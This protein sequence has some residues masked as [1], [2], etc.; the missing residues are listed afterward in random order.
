[1]DLV[2]RAILPV[3]SIPVD[4][5]FGIRVPTSPSTSSN[6]LT[7]SYNG[8]Q[9]GVPQTATS[10]TL[11]SWL[12]NYENGK[13]YNTQFTSIDPAAPRNITTS[14]TSTS[15]D[16]GNSFT[17]ATALADGQKARVVTTSFSSGHAA[18]AAAA[19]LDGTGSTSTSSS[20]ASN[21][22]A[23]ATANALGDV[24][25]MTS[26]NTVSALDSQSIMN[27]QDAEAASSCAADSG[28]S[29]SAQAEETNTLLIP[30]GQSPDGTKMYWL[31]SSAYAACAAGV[32]APSQ[33]G[34]SS[35][36][37]QASLTGVKSTVTCNGV[38]STQQQTSTT[39]KVQVKGAYTLLRG[40][41][42]AVGGQRVASSTSQC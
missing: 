11:V 32:N 22:T 17:N 42:G 7:I 37:S 25:I 16:G 38:T 5:S 8:Y 3:V 13:A 14:S 24:V 36:G 23:V 31:K 40:F 6:P 39:F 34:S 20:G 4:F 18:S 15:Q 30:I 26:A 27:A 35:S 9:F 2:E 28:P 10:G 41:N 19:A 12:A 21:S 29:A 33:G 1:M